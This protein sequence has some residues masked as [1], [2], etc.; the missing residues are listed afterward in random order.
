MR[1][2]GGTAP[3]AKWPLDVANGALLMAE[4]HPMLRPDWPPSTGRETGAHRDRCTERAPAPPGHGGGPDPRWLDER[5]LQGAAPATLPRFPH[6]RH[7][8]SSGDQVHPG[9]GA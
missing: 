3:V 4:E 2:S 5:H 1:T 7:A 9:A 6:P 8:W